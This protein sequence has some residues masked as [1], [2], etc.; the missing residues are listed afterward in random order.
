MLRGV[1]D[2]L[3]EQRQYERRQRPV[4][5]VIP[6]GAAK[7]DHAAPAREL[8]VSSMFRMALDAAHAAVADDN[9]RVLI[10]SALHGLVEL[11]DVLEPYD[12]KMGDEGCVTVE[13][14]VEQCEQLG[15]TWEARADVYAALPAAYFDKLDAALKSI[16]VYA[17]PVYEATR[18]IGEHRKVCR[19]VR[20]S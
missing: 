16:D 5:Y 19:I 7:L 15:L 11:D 14:I 20:D 10:L 12:V 3:Y 8:Y 4:T 1:S 9:G 2:T 13:R 17:A 6:C 18:G